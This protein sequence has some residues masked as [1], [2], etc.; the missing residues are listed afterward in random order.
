MSRRK[1]KKSLSLVLLGIII[2]G[3]ILSAA[4]VISGFKLDIHLS[5]KKSVSESESILTDIRKVFTF[6]TVEYVYKS[7]FPFDFYDEKT[8]WY[9]LLNKRSKGVNLTSKEKDSRELYDICSSAGIKLTGKNYQF[10]VVTSLIKAGLP[11]PQSITQDSIL[12]EG[13]NISIRLPKPEIT[14]LIIEDPDSST[15]QYPDMDIDPLHWKQIARYVQAHIEE[16]VLNKGILNKAD[17]RL[18]NFI[19]SFLHEAGFQSVTFIQ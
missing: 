3:G 7:V 19:S 15:Y 14:E 17:S 6:S 4:Y 8:D 9:M 13:K 10:L 12:I 18:R 16:K 2:F 5:S 11:S 1:N